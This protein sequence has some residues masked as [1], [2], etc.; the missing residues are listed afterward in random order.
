MSQNGPVHQTIKLSTRL[1]KLVWF[2]KVSTDLNIVNLK[3][4]FNFLNFTLK[5]Q[6]K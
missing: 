3:Q 6:V 2:E 1:K 4:V 5:R